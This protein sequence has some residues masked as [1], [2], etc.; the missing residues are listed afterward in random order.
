MY[1]INVTQNSPPKSG[2]SSIFLII[3]LAKTKMLPSAVIK[4]SSIVLLIGLLVISKI[5]SSLIIL[6]LSLSK[7]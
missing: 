7:K 3:Y 6:A 2:F 4:S 1:H 5:Y